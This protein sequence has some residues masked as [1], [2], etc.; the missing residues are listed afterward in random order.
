MRALVC[1]GAPAAKLAAFSGRHDCRCLGN[2]M[3]G[4]LG[5]PGGPAHGG[6]TLHCQLPCCILQTTA[7]AMILRIFAF[8]KSLCSDFDEAICICS[9]LVPR[10]LASL[11]LALAGGLVRIMHSLL[12]WRVGRARR[13]LASTRAV[14]GGCSQVVYVL[15]LLG[16]LPGVSSQG[17]SPWLSLSLWLSLWLSLSLSL[18]LWLPRSRRDRARGARGIVR[19]APRLRPCV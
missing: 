8:G 10:L 7:V 17:L 2:S 6:P 13:L 18:S 9:G 15:V 14:F 11:A 12:T 16:A 4:I 3:R 5:S 19:L 1:T